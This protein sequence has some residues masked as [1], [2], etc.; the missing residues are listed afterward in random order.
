[1]V[2]N[3]SRYTQFAEL[4]LCMSYAGMAPVEMFGGSELPT[5][6]ESGYPL[7]LSPYGFFWITL[8]PKAVPVEEDHR[9][10]LDRNVLII[11][12]FDEVFSTKTI[13]EFRGR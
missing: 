1:M 3:L 2:A 10:A 7:T 8:Q 5:I 12:S 11:D 4:D 6:G 13:A 9:G